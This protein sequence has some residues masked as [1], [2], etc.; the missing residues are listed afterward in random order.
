MESDKREIDFLKEQIAARETAYI[1]EINRLQDY[2]KINMERCKIKEINCP[3]FTIKLKINPPSTDILDESQIP[4]QYMRTREIVKTEIKP[5]KNAIKE[6]VLKTGVQIPGAF[7]TQ[8]T[9][10]KISIDKL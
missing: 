3:Y 4:E 2:L 6:E 5:D 7:V 1:K 10:V 9:Q 8:K